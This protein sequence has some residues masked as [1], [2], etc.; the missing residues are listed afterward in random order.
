M[1][2]KYIIYH[3]LFISG[4]LACTPD[5]DELVDFTD[6]KISKIELGAD[7]RQ[8]IADGVSKLTLNPMLFQSYTYYDLNENKDSTVYGKIP[9]DRLVDAPI[10]KCFL[11]DGTPLDGLTY[12]TTDLSKTE[13]GF[14]AVVNDVKSN[15]FKVAIRKP[16]PDDAYQT[17][18]YPVIF[19]IIQDKEM[20]ELGQG[21]GSDIVYYA[22]DVINNCFSRRAAFS[23]NGADTKVRFQLAEYD[24]K[25][26]KMEQKGIH[27]YPLSSDR[28]NDL[29]NSKIKA[30]ADICWDYKKYL[31]I[32]VIQDFG[33]S[34]KAPKYMLET[35]DPD[36]IKG[37][38][39][40]QLTE[41][42][43][44]AQ[45]WSI[46]DI[47]LVFNAKDFATEDVGYATQM[48]KCFGLLTTESEKED[49]C[50]D[51]FTYKSYTEPWNTQL[52]GSNSRLKISTDGL[53][54][55]SVNV[56]DNSS[57][58]NTISMDQVKRIRMITDY[59]PHRWAW[60]SQWAFTGKN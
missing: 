15:V 52:G 2:A 25:G 21:I 3:L 35:A 10:V 57:Y 56:M 4:L 33:N 14:Y 44:A 18:V 31:N 11:E 39:F 28:L 40:E 32:W 53:V 60:K 1:K 59:C 42:E 45:D 30:N 41:E 27:Y 8:L 20:V 13:Q 36:Q 9:V 34:G 37:I 5:Q 43:I 16:F 23:P 50:D 55:Y 46:G 54:F 29:D 48:A 12:K 58:K 26:R 17:I 6:I 47:G 7:H 51:T 24:P 22:F 38:S 19:H 49:Y